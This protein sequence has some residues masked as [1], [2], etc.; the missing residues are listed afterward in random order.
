MY[1]LFITENLSR[2]LYTLVELL[3]MKK[4]KGSLPIWRKDRAKLL[5]LHFVH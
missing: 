5:G 3:D 2:L 4:L 1:I